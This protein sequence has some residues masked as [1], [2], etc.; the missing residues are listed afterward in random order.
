MDLKLPIPLPPNDVEEKEVRPP[1]PAD[2]KEVNPAGEQNVLSTN[3]V[4]V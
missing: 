2:P 3:V 4:P 1:C